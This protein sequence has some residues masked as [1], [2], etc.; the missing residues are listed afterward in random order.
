MKK[1]WIVTGM[2][3]AQRNSGMVL[4]SLTRHR[5]GAKPVTRDFVKDFHRQCGGASWNRTSDLCIISATL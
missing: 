5:Y 3:E 4:D 2:A 1:R